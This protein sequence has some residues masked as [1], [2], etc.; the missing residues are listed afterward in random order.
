MYIWERPD[1]PQ[2]RW[3]AE[4]LQ[5][6][7]AEAHLK[8]GRLLGRIQA[9][10]FDLRL[11]A[12]LLAAT[13]EAVT[14]ADIEGEHLDP[15]AVRSSIARR[16][17]VPG[18]A[19]GPEDRQVEGMVAMTLDA[20]TALDE[21]ITRER[22][23]GWHAA[24][25]PTGYSGLRKIATGTWRDDRDGPMQIISGPV[26]RAKVHYQAPPADRIDGEMERFLS[27][28]N[29]PITIDGI[30]HAALA[31]LWFV[32]IHPFE[33]GNGRIARALAERSLAR[34]EQC[35]QRFYS[36]AS[37]IRRERPAYYASLEAAQ[38]GDLEITPRLLWFISCFTKAVEAAEVTCSHILHKATFWQRCADRA[39]N[40]RQ[41][42][43]LNRLLDGFDGKLTAK[44]WAA[45]TK[46]S[47][48]TAQRDIRELVEAGILLKNEGGSKNTSYDLAMPG[49]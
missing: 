22:L 18:A 10:G 28:L 40:E 17:G 42:K 6:L 16:L 47:V 15:S 19:L 26:G 49:P 35:Q 38:K 2:F 39:L 24:L 44:K 32:T 37:E 33:D 11:E 14:S 30:V 12:E 20:T 8:Q 36:L 21:P 34:S 45:M 23:F 9:L 4:Q 13:E 31:H 48:P 25:F 41:R 7:L 27:W 5:P 3:N 46:S 1:W 43:V 29:A